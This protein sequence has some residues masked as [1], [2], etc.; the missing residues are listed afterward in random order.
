[1]RSKFLF[2]SL[3]PLLLL[4]G[5]MTPTSSVQLFDIAKLREF[6]RTTLCLDYYLFRLG[7][8]IDVRGNQ[9]NKILGWNVAS[10]EAMAQLEEVLLEKGISH[11][12]INGIREGRIFVGMSRDALYAAYGEPDAVSEPIFTSSYTLRHVYLRQNYLRILGSK[13]RSRTVYVYTKE[14]VVTRWEH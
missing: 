4:A 7:N 5:C 3:L 11:E 2:P 10:P 6:D 1:M 9:H 12:E 8:L 14:G 13:N